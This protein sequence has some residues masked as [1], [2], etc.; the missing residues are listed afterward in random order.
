MGMILHFSAI[1][2]A[3]AQCGLSMS[4][5]QYDTLLT[6][7]GYGTYHLS[8]PQWSPDSGTLASVKIS[9]VVNLHYGFTLRNADLIPSTYSVSVGRQDKFTSPALT[10]PFVNLTEQMVGVYPLTPGSQASQSKF[11]L[12]DTYTNTDSIFGAV[13]GFLG[14]GKVSFTYS[15]ITYT[16]VNTANN[17]SYFFSAAATDTI[18]FSVTYRYCNAVLLANSITHFDAA[19]KKPGVVQL[20][21]ITENEVA[22]H[23][24]EIERSRDGSHFISVADLPA[25]AGS[26]GSAN[27]MQEDLL[28]EPYETKYWYRL[29]IADGH[30][31]FGYSKIRMVNLGAT[32][33]NH[34]SLYPNPAAGYV[35]IVFDEVSTG[36]WQV[37]ILSVTGA[38]I[39]RNYY[40][41]TR[42]ARLDF[43]G[44]LASGTYFIRATGGPAQ[45]I[46]V[47]PLLVSQGIH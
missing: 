24:Y 7:I 35:N 1:T 2:P 33:G 13:T 27:Y 14:T 40:M 45:K 10:I 8:F 44:K 29:K 39:Q 22:G 37:D 34:L 36:D 17:A 11:L 5:R 42:Q 18:H 21:W 43:Q 31:G 47:S 9:A 3:A 6:G 41:N 12:L 26:S 30:G 4:T 46:I 38:L 23:S 20:S 32:E 19:L 15:P 28:P 16:N 25:N